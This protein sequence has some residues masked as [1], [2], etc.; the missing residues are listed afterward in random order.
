MLKRTMPDLLAAVQKA[1]KRKKWT[2]YDLV[3]ALRDKRPGGKPVPPSVVYAFLRGES[4]IN[5]ADLGLIFDALGMSV[6]GPE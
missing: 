2:R 3:K 6:E 1:L 4:T 5:S